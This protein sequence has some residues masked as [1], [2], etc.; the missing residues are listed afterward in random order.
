MENI[1]SYYKGKRVVVLGARGYLGSMLCPLLAQA[2]AEVKALAKDGGDITTADFWQQVFVE[3]VDVIFHLAAYESREPDARLDLKV[4]ALSVLECLEAA[5]NLPAKPRI[6]FMSSSN[7]AGIASGLP[8]NEKTPDNPMT[9][10]AIHK[11]LAENYL[12]HYRTNLNIKSMTLRLANVYGPSATADLSK[13]VAVNKIAAKA[14][15]GGSLELYEN[16]NKARDF[17][18]MTDA[19]NAL[20]LAG[21]FCERAGS[22]HYVVGSGE[23]TDF[24]SITTILASIAEE[25]L[26]EKL[27]IL[28]SDT[29]LPLVEMRE[30]VADSALFK[31]L[32]GWQAKVQLK[33]GLEK[34]FDYF[35]SENKSQ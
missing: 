13:R 18:Y 20:L 33:E 32:T 1:F 12:Y 29:E 9:I 15:E 11:L 19:L 25:R 5:K 3:P 17:L 21:E 16:K 27:S 28:E 30:F 24:E 10:Y 2:G 6:V 35:F 14:A 4:N 34:T 7:L 22:R 26:G 8:V 31:E 23:R